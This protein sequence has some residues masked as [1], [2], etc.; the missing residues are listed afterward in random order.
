MR[1]RSALVL[2]LAALCGVSACGRRRVESSGTTFV[3]ARGKDSPTADPRP[4]FFRQLLA[5]FSSSIVSPGALA[6]GETFVQRNPVGTGPFRLASWST[7]Q[8]ITLDAN[9][10]WYG[11]RPKIDHLVLKVIQE[12]HDAYM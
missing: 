5:M 8:E 3:Y 9:P 1:A 12:P 7:A 6:K 2:A 10:D 4:P 11:G